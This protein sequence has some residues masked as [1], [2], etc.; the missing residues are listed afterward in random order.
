[1]LNF[2]YLCSRFIIIPKQRKK[3][4]NQVCNNFEQHHI[5]EKLRNSLQQKLDTENNELQS[6]L[7]KV[8]KIYYLY[9]FISYKTKKVEC[10]KIQTLFVIYAQCM[11]W[12]PDE[13]KVRE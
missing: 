12:F 11:P 9:F 3:Q 13:I 6:V 10:C 2:I 1:M 5:Q 8:I 7:E 4:I